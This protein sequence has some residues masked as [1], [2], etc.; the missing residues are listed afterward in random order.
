VRTRLRTLK[1]VS[2][3]PSVTRG[4]GRA[5]ESYERSRPGYPADAVSWLVER[6]RLGPGTTVIDLAAG[7][8]KLTRLLVPTRATVIAVEPVDELRAQLEAAV[9]GAEPRAGY[10]ERIP[11]PDAGADAVT[12]AQAFHWFA[13]D[14]ALDEVARVLRPGGRLGLIWNLRD[15]GDDLQRAFTEIVEPLRDDEPSAYDGRWRRVLEASP[16]FGPIEKRTFR[17]EQW[18][19]ADGLAER[20]S[21]ISFVSAAP[22]DRRTD[23]IARVR[24][25]AGEGF[26]RFPYVTAAYV[27]ER[28][29]GLM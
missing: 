8:G 19:D 6:I 24:A 11:L 1:S 17:Y 10:A 12:V 27:S 5:A 26:I 4:F 14:V 28:A 9:P 18:L 15:Q 13:T 2:V 29:G 21:S 25:L 7:T 23:V 16:L 22:A 20:A 3:H